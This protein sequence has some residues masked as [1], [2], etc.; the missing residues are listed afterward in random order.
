MIRVM[1]AGRAAVLFKRTFPK[2]AIAVCMSMAAAAEAMAGGLGIREQ[3]TFF[4]GASFAGA[5]AGGG[6]SASFWNPAAMSSAGYGLITESHFSLIVADFDVHGKSVGVLPGSALPPSTTPVGDR[7]AI[8]PM[9]IVGASYAA[10]RLN[11]DIVLGLAISSPFGSKNKT[12]QATWSGQYHYRSSELLTI[13]V[14][15]ILSYRLS[16]GLSIGVGPQIQYMSLSLKANP[17]GGLAPSQ[18]SSALEG[19]DIGVG[20]TAGVL[21]QPGAATSIGLGYRSAVSHEIEGDAAMAGGFLT[22]ALG[23]EAFAP[24][25]FSAKLQTPEMVTLSARQSLTHDT[26]LLATIEWTNWSRLDEVEFR[27]TA[28]GGIAAQPVI[29]GQ[30]LSVLDFHWNDGWFFA[31]G[32][33]W[34]YSPSL[35]LRAGAAYEISPIREAN[36]RKINVAD[37]DRIWLSAGATY[38]VTEHMSVDVAYTHIFFDD[39]PIDSLTTSP[40]TSTTPVRRFVGSADQAADIVALSMKTKW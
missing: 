2:G 15:P 39:A 20:V 35:T 22:T 6:L 12:D 10:W 38:A 25:D 8:D 23:T 19:D 26:R 30:T 17:S 37:S 16:P 9:A 7:V 24:A 29:P 14:N 40:G 33:E 3:S 28:G 4:Q 5:A 18:S 21:W 13:N 1:R 36:Q 34:D 27:A 32:G 11:D 31:L